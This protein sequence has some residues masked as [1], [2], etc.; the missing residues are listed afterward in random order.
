MRTIFKAISGFSASLLLIALPVQANPDGGTVVGGNGN[1]TI[2]GQGTTLT[3]INQ[4]ANRVIINWRDFSIG[5]GELTRF[6][7]PS[8]NSIA[9]NRVTSGNLS[10]IYG[11]LQANGRVFVINPN[12]ILVG[13]HGQIDTKGF[14]ASTLNVSD[15]NFMGG[16]NLMFGGNS[17]AGVRNDGAIRAL[18]GDVFLIGHTVENSGTIQAADGTVG[19]AAGAQVKLMQSGGEHLSVIAGA[20]ANSSAAIGVNNVGTVE[21][22]SAELK[23]AGGNIYALAINN[24]GVVRATTAA[25]ENGHIVLKAAGGNI[26]NSGILAASTRNG[27]GGSIVWMVDT[28]RPTRQR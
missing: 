24:G 5:L 16:G 1:A 18:G 12:G 6:N 28:M 27:G 17:T 19:L 4:N 7:Q 2:T 25:S 8:G 3:T 14:L 15:K 23:A 22:A 11:S 26:E 20:P 9:L 21:A 13:A 10:E